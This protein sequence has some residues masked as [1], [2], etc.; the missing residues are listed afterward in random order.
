M[1]NTY[2]PANAPTKLG[3][4]VTIASRCSHQPDVGAEVLLVP[5]SN[6]ASPVSRPTNSRGRARVRNGRC[7]T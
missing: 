7:T 2:E 5:S 1:N 4:S 6:V 3:Q